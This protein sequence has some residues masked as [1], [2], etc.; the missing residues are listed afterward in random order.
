VTDQLRL[1][2]ANLPE[3]L[4]KLEILPSGADAAIEPAGEGNINW[5]RRVRTSDGA[6]WVVKQAR[7]ALER[8]P[9]YRVST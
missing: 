3:Y 7:P 2:E 4:R 5:V 6:S 8:F 9:E 1:T